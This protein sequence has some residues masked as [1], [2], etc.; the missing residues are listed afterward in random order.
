M[1]PLIWF[2]KTRSTFWAHPC[3]LFLREVRSLKTEG[4]VRNLNLTLGAEL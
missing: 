4:I 1:P 3:D 2:Q